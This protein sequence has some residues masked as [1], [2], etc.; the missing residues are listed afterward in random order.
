MSIFKRFSGNKSEKKVEEEAEMALDETLCLTDEIEDKNPLPKTPEDKMPSLSSFTKKEQEMIES[1]LSDKPLP[2]D[3]NVSFEDKFEQASSLNLKADAPKTRSQKSVDDILSDDSYKS[4]LSLLRGELTEPPEE[5]EAKLEKPASETEMLASEEEVDEP[6]IEEEISAEDAIP[7]I[8]ETPIEA[9]ET[10]GLEADTTEIEIEIETMTTEDEAPELE[11]KTAEPA[12]RSEQPT[13][14]HRRINLG[15]MRMDVSSIISD[16]ENGDSMFRRAQQRVENLTNYIER[17][18]VD[19]SLLDRLE[20]E[21]RAL[22]SE[23]LALSSELEKRKSKIANLSTG[24]EDLQRRFGD[25]QSELD[26]TQAKLAHSK[27][28]HEHAEHNIS[29]LNTE[30]QETRLKAE[31]YN[32]ELGVE[33][34][35]NTSLRSRI[36]ALTEQLDKVTS[37]KLGFAKQIETL[38]IDLDDQVQTR[39]KLRDETADLRHALEEAH[40]ENT[41]MRGQIGSVHEDI[42]GFKTQY[43][44]NLLKRDERIAQ[45]ESQLVEMNDR[46][47]L[48]EEIVETATRD[49]SSLR[50]ERT[51]QDLERERLQLALNEQTNQLHKSEEALLK[52]RQAT[53]ELDMRYREVSSTLA[54]NSRQRD[55]VASSVSP[56]I[57]PAATYTTTIETPAPISAPTRSPAARVSTKSNDIS[58][59][60][61]IEKDDLSLDGPGEAPAAERIAPIPQL[62]DDIDDLLTD[63][64]LGLR[65]SN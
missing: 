53:S 58:P 33:N 32:N 51:T 59:M 30:L 35:E 16:I 36:T 26:A 7:E 41:Q 23:N 60:F 11:T 31:R 57:A 55:H 24:L 42:R 52:S 19:F 1:I 44:F 22:K 37:E 2:K 21:N 27:K 54:Q 4:A 56:D 17:A 46:L 34:R 62:N 25:T 38:K 29:R 13:T 45:L 5:L 14:G 43:E 47:R 63:Y 6:N 65:K 28:N 3:D 50:Q 12:Y 10:E 20:P 9:A 64:K 8:E 18:E 61:S 40:R 48:K 39:R 15:D 49:I